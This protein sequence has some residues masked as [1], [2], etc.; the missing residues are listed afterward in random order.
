MSER[1]WDAEM[2]KIDRHLA[3]APG[4]ARLPLEREGAPA[5]VPSRATSAFGVYARL[6]LA[7]ALGVGILFWPY[8]S[9]CGFGLAG[10][11]GAVTILIVAGL[12]S[13]VWTWRHRAARAH[14]LSLLLVMWGLALASVDV[15]SRTGWAK[16]SE[17]HPARWSCG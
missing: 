7:G 17:N 15:L 13:S 9:R 2:K 16:P 3:V 5:P 4:P 1:D 11:L 14:V 8:G 10:F 12:W 6:A